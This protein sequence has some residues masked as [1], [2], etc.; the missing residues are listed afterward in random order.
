MMGVFWA[1]LAA[2]GFSAKA[3]FVKLAYAQVAQGETLAAVTLLMLRM[4]YALPGFVW[5]AL[6]TGKN[7]PAMDWRSRGSIVLLGLLGYYGASILDFAGLQYISAGLERL[8]LF[9]YPAL[10]LLIS[11][12]V[13]KQSVGR[14]EMAAL[15]LCFVG[16]AI[17]F[18][19]DWHFSGEGSAVWMG[20][21]LVF[22]SALCYALY[23]TGS[24]HMMRSMG[25]ARFTA[26]AM[27]ASTMGVTIHFLT[28]Q[29]LSTLNQP[30]AIQAYACAMAVFSTLIPVFAQSLAIRHMGP[31]RA[32]L[33]GMIG[34]ILT[35]G[36]AGWIL[37]EALSVWQLAG[38]ALVIS[39]VW[40]AGR[41]PS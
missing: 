22:A 13:W 18:A 15:M 29:A 20:T 39:G 12:W 3:I 7:A 27:L 37:D 35:I 33:V 30:L 40:L 26:W 10:T 41:R 5:V 19:H 9:T 21:G 36:L 32:A 6:R 17:A 11:A 4:A 1:I 34:P 23:L 2:L 28:T 16:I 25:V 31:G 14:R 8:I 24:G 38:A